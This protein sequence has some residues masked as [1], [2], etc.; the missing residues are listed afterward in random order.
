MNAENF[1]SKI[2][3][4]LT[5][6]GQHYFMRYGIKNFKKRKKREAEAS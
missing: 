2:S 1:L 5:P 6:S 3:K 4:I